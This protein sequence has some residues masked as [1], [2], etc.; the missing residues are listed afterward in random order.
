MEGWGGL[1]SKS[2]VATFWTDENVI[3]LDQGD[4]TC[5]KNVT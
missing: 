3:Y 2:H 5:W 4:G 1:I